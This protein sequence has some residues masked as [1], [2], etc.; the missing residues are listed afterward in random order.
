M[1]DNNCDFNIVWVSCKNIHTW[2]DSPL[3]WGPHFQYFSKGG[4]IKHMVP[5][6]FKS[7][8]IIKGWP[9]Y[10]ILILK[11]LS[12]LV[13]RWYRINKN[14]TYVNKYPKR[15][16]KSLLKKF[17]ILEEY[18]QRPKCCI[19]LKETLCHLPN[20]NDSI[21][22]FQ[23]LRL[24]S[25]ITFDISLIKENPKGRRDDLPETLTGTIFNPS[26]SHVL[27]GQQACVISIIILTIWDN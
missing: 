14:V 25:S 15:N 23:V 18:Q 24:S 9:L 10:I 20:V 21:S 22:S 12:L 16:I 13:I 2:V 27:C 6:Y 11:K 1:F 7:V 8:T 26:L 5:F 19:D 3:F 4:G 17:V